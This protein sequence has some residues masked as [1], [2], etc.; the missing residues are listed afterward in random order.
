MEIPNRFIVTVSESREFTA[1]V[2]AETFEEAVEKVKRGSLRV[3]KNARP[4]I[5]A[6]EMLVAIP[7]IHVDVTRGC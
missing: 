5:P 3:L 2:E 4:D 6:Y 7:D 1:S